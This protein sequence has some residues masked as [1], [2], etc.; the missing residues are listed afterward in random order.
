WV[1]TADAGVPHD[2]GESHAKDGIR[3]VEWGGAVQLFSG[4][5]IR[6]PAASGR[7]RLACDAFMRA[8]PRATS[9]GKGVALP[10]VMSTWTDMFS[11]VAATQPSLAWKSCSKKCMRLAS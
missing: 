2:S 7:G 5:A 11:D 3:R 6:R 1:A 9:S 4:I 8:S 10:A